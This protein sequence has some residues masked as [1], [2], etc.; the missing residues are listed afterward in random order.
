MSELERRDL[1]AALS[2]V[3]GGVVGKEQQEVTDQVLTA[4]RGQS[5]ASDYVYKCI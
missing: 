1:R 4:L 5:P 3:E 2:L